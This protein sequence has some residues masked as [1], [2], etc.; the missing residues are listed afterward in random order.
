L[1]LEPS[2]ASA[3]GAS[4]TAAAAAERILRPNILGNGRDKKEEVS[5]FCELE[6]KV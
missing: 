1:K 4:S 5:D 2:K 6:Q 3:E